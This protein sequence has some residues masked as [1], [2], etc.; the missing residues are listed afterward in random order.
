MNSIT[1]PA[2][3]AKQNGSSLLITKMKAGDIA[4]YTTINRYD[5]SKKPG[6]PDQGYQR[7]EEMPRVKKFARWLEEELAA[8]RQVRMPTAILLSAR[9]SDLRLSAEGTI[10]LNE[11][12]KLF[13]IDGQHRRGGFD[14]AITKKGLTQFSDY[15][16]VVV[17]MLD[18]DKI[19]EMRQ[20]S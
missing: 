13:L 17:I 9:G 6:D 8:K 19:D 16:I 7:P 15:E 3:L 1:V 2:I 4:K 14:Y 11:G 18:V 20:F 5:A 12:Q 10:T